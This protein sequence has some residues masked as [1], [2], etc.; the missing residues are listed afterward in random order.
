MS[1]DARSS[2]RLAGDTGAAL[3]EAA[4]IGPLF[5]VVVLSILEYGLVYRDYL[6]ASDA[7][8][9]AARTGG[10]QGNDLTTASQ[11]A[12]YSIVRSMRD[13]LASLDYSNVDRMVVFKAAGPDS[14]S[15]VSQTPAACRT[16]SSSSS[17]SQCNLYF[18][19]PAFGAVQYGDDN[20]FECNPTA[21]DVVACGWDPTT[22]SNGDGT[23]G[24]TVGEPDYLGVYVKIDHKMI[25]GIFGDEFTIEDASIYQI[26]QGPVAL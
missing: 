23:G 11:T 1:S 13:S 18:A 12:D 15:P 10:V 9:S 7:V 24:S 20:Y 17:A 22:R 16:G 14:G 5:I 21:G 8:A 6:T 25:S 19:S 2:R 3:L 4:V 26:E